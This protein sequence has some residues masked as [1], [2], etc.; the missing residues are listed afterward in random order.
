M[1]PCH[2]SPGGS[3]E[4]A[5]RI[6]NGSGGTYTLTQ[7]GKAIGGAGI[8]AGIGSG[9]WDG[10]G[11]FHQMAAGSG[12]DNAKPEDVERKTHS[13]IE[14]ALKGRDRHYTCLMHIW[15]QP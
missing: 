2:G 11:Y 13:Q 8:H 5:K 1:V 3:T 7:S 10:S 12:S 14:Q 15:A 9:Y 6:P 4:C